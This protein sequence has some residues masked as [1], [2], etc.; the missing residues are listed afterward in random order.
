M[1]AL[2][3]TRSLVLALA[4][5]VSPAVVAR[6]Q[7][8]GP[9]SYERKLEAL[10]QK[11]KSFD[12]EAVAA[13]KSYLERAN[14]RGMFEQAI[15]ALATGLADEIRSK[16]PKMN[17][18]QAREFMDAF[19]HSAFVDNADIVQDYYLIMWLEIFSKDELVAMNQFYSSQVGSSILKK[20]PMMMGRMPELMHLTQTYIVPR[21]L[22]AARNSMKA[23]GVEITI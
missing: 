4:L 3:L 22:A 11:L 23:R 20:M 1:R 19:L 16:N 5:G 7:V 21:A 15:P 10:D 6:A 18:E 9:D 12:P 2:A 8:E 17:D 14:L 13:A